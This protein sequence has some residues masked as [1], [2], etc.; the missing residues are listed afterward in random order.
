MIRAL[1]KSTL[2]TLRLLPAAGRTRE[3]FLSGL[4]LLRYRLNVLRFR[5]AAARLPIP[6]RKLNFTVTN[7]FDVEW[8]VKS[9]WLAAQSIRLALERNR[10]SVSDFAAILDFG[11]G[12][13]R[14]I[15][16]WR[17]L[18]AAVY[19]TDYNPDLIRWCEQNLSFAKFEVNRTDPPLGYPNDSF[20]LVYA[21]SVFTHL[22]EARQFTWMEEL[23]RVVKPG[24]Y[25]VITTHGDCPFYSRSL[26]QA[27]LARFREG[28]L[29]V[30]GDGAV[31]S[32]QFSAFHPTKYV[33]STL[34]RGFDVLS[35]LEG[36]AFGN[37]YQDLYL[38]R[39]L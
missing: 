26:N 29:V 30:R 27:E 9:G 16:Y 33:Q 1:A 4:A 22:D 28:Q 36:G 35:Y 34:A 8:Y 11:C 20:D 38:L 10:L 13:G 17:D 14:V 7:T 6:P 39:K 12:S 5:R 23:R 15:R 32:N 2:S 24:H 37:P 19:G 31:G 3:T 18:P 21:L 25:V